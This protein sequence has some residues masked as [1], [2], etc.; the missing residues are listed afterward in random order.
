LLA[1]AEKCPV[2]RTLSSPVQILT[3]LLT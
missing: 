3:R 1:I 2:H